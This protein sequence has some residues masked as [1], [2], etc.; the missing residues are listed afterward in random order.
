MSKPLIGVLAVQGAF[1]E[2]EHILSA[3]GADVVELRQAADVTNDLDGIVLPGG[4]SSVQGKLVR[5]LGMFEPLK[6]LINQGVPVLATCA[7]MILLASEV[8]QGI[9]SGANSSTADKPSIAAASDPAAPPYFATIPMS[10][11][12]N[13][14]GRQL[15][16]FATS[17][18]FGDFENVPMIFI[19]GPYVESVGE[20]VQVLATVNDNIV[21]VRYKNQLSMSFHP[22]LNNDTRIHEMFLSFIN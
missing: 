9:G 14:Y 8:T 17:D 2:H 18:N 6:V 15:G 21:A 12:R 1:I 11:K 16:S 20:D 3:L 10:V 22:E 5:E 19:R 7:G 4:E 13:A